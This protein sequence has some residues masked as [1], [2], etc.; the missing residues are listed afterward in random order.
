VFDIVLQKPE[1]RTLSHSELRS[2]ARTGVRAYGR[3]V[4]N[5]QFADD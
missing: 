5:L 3:E 4:R 2:A 1:L